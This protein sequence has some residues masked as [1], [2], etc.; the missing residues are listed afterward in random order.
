MP[1]E[2]GGPAGFD[3]THRG[4]LD[5]G[6]PMGLLVAR[7]MRAKNVRQFESVGASGSG[8][9]RGRPTH[10]LAWRRERREAEQLNRRPVDGHR[11]LRDVQ[12]AHRCLN[13]S[14][15][16]QTLNGGQ[17]D[18]HLEEV[19]REDVTHRV[20]AAPLGD[21]GPPLGVAIRLPDGCHRSLEIA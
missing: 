3:R 19:R 14:M 10:G 9:P 15:A 21:P 20:D 5:A 13:R 11:R 1:A 4:A 16:E 2:D 7:P 17:V 6:Q 12:V 18:A 8:R